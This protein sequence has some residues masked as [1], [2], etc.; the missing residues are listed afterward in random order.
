MAKE[1]DRHHR[2]LKVCEYCEEQ[3]WAQKETSRFCSRNH[4]MLWKNKFQDNSLIHKK[5]SESLKNNPKI[6]ANA[7][8]QNSSSE[9]IKSKSEKAKKQW[10]ERKEEMI[11][12]QIQSYKDDPN[13]AKDRMV[14]ILA[15]P[16]RNKKLSAAMHRRWQEDYQGMI[17]KCIL[18]TLHIRNSSLE[19]KFEKVLIEK[20]IKYEK[21]FVLENKIYDFYLPEKNML[22][23]C[24]GLF[25]HPVD[26]SKIKYNI[27]REN[28]V[29]DRYKD[30]LAKR[31]GYQL[32]R[33]NEK[34]NLQKNFILCII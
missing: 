27:Q 12:K 33:V 20:G 2:F 10:A 6:I 25:W 24:D 4:A 1:K 13:I 11:A 18:P 30:R 17:R 29:N 8:Q 34:S 19:Q 26:E 7:L 5:I 21:Q 32:Y 28:L 31:Y 3:Y 16:E 23:E 22:V 15:N 9:I 14:K